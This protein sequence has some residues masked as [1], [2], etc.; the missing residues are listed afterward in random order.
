MQNHRLFSS[1][2]IF[3]GSD[4]KPDEKNKERGLISNSSPSLTILVPLRFIIISSTSLSGEH[5]AT[6]TAKPSQSE[7]TCK[8]LLI[9][10]QS[11]KITT[12]NVKFTYFS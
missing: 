10:S 3:Y 6:A 11:R 5:L 4:K 9:N 7:P 2:N 1:N 8:H 12:P